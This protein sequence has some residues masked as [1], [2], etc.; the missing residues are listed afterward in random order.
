MTWITS[1]L[2]YPGALDF[3]QNAMMSNVQVFSKLRSYIESIRDR[4]TDLQKPIVSPSAG[5]SPS[6]TSARPF[7]TSPRPFSTSSRPFSTSSRSTSSTSDTQALTSK[8]VAVSMG[9]MGVFAKA[10]KL[11]SSLEKQLSVIENQFNT[12]IEVPCKEMQKQLAELERARALASEAYAAY[13]QA[14]ANLRTAADRRS[15]NLSELKA[16]FV[17][18]QGRAHDRH[19]ELN[20]KA[21]VAAEAIEGVLSAYEEAE[22]WK[23]NQIQG[24]VIAAAE[25]GA[26][27]AASFGDVSK[28][29]EALK[30][31]LPREEQLL[32]I[33]DPNR[34][35]DPETCDEFRLASMDN[36]VA[37]L[38][39]PVVLF[40]NAA[41]EKHPLYKVTQ[42]CQGQANKLSVAPGDIVCEIN[43]KE[44]FIE[45]ETINGAKGMI[46]KSALERVK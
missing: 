32:R 46:P 26:Q 20:D 45:A 31:G 30:V 9:T 1:S 35:P 14:G 24:F 7:G 13:E 5:I 36:R 3:L 10:G 11:L 44:D 43:E 23:S 18:A 2:D 42:Q 39:D 15:D 27:F 19:A 29:F 12:M 40:P 8:C 28:S 22:K 34:L 37:Q 4:F 6:S 33:F 17:A 38:V 41:K 21:V 25:W 16:A